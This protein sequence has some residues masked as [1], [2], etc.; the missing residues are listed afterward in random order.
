[1]RSQRSIL[2]CPRRGLLTSCEEEG[3]VTQQRQLPL[4]EER[5]EFRLEAGG[6][7]LDWGD[8]NVLPR[9]E[10]TLQAKGVWGPGESSQRRRIS[11]QFRSG[12]GGALRAAL[13]AQ[14]GT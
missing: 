1:M 13:R 11:S 3:D 10:P 5:R 4:G 7:G 6:Y 8:H 12:T 9:P 14:S 2:H